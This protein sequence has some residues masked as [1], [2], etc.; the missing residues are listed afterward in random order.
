MDAALL[1]HFAAG[2][3]DFHR[4]LDIGTGNGVI[5]IMLA[6]LCPRLLLAGIEI[7]PALAGLA[8]KNVCY[9]HLEERVTIC[10]GDVR[11]DQAAIHRCRYD[12]VLCNPPFF[13]LGVGLVS[14]EPELAVARHE[15]QLTLPELLQSV[16]R[17]LEPGG[18][19][20]LIHRAERMAECLQ[21]L[22]GFKLQAARLRMIHSRLQEPAKLFL[23]ACVRGRRSLRIL[24]PLI[25]YRRFGGYSAALKQML[26]DG[27]RPASGDGCH[28]G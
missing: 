4:G 14:P 19:F 6:H 24:P 11:D 5:P 10:Q 9:N 27:E 2:L 1:A 20:A 28:T 18:T 12:L 7:Q 8:Q 25:V 22:A 15:L 21:L 13:K 16:D 3:G 26:A 17:L 23:L